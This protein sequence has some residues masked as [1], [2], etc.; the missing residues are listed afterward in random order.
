M[1]NMDPTSDSDPFASVSS[2]SADDA[3]KAEPI[4]YEPPRLTLL[5]TLPESTGMPVSNFRLGDEP[6]R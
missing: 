6:T 5:G 1:P 2:A 3:P 4:A